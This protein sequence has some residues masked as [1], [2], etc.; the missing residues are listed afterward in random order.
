M[1]IE[2]LNQFFTQY[3]PALCTSAADILTNSYHFPCIAMDRMN[4][5][6][7]S[8]VQSLIEVHQ[9]FYNDNLKKINSSYIKNIIKSNTE[10][11]KSLT[12]AN[13]SIEF[14]DHADQLM[15][16]LNSNYNL[17]HFGDHYKIIS[18][19]ILSTRVPNIPNRT[20]SKESELAKINSQV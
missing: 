9:H 12:C 17:M 6:P 13:V 7:C 14:Y 20:K 4:F 8:T 15:Y 1:S 10:L 2:K 11:S 18:W 5:I 16:T 3:T 19:E